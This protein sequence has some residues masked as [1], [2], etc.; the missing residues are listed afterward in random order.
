ME[1]MMMTIIFIDC[2]EDCHRENHQ[3]KKTISRFEEMNE[4]QIKCNFGPLWSVLGTN[5]DY[6]RVFLNLSEMTNL[7]DAKLKLKPDFI[8]V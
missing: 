7:I 5:N 3:R 6:K 2:Y 4:K 8:Q 1:M